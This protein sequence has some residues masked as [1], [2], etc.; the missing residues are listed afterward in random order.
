MGCS[1]MG[2]NVKTERK[3]S[4]RLYGGPAEREW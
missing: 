2:V 4:L 1:L 3:T